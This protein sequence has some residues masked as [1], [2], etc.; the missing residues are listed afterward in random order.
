MS[1]D[2]K[3]EDGFVIIEGNW[4]RLVTLDLMLDAPS[5]RKNNQGLRRALVHDHKDGLTV[6][7]NSDY[8]GG[9]TIQGETKTDSLTTDSLKA[10]QL[11]TDS[12][13]ASQLTT[14]SLK[15]G[16]FRLAYSSVSNLVLGD[17]NAT[18]MTEL[19]GPGLRVKG[20]L[21]VYQD[22]VFNE[23]IQTP[24]IVIQ[25]KNP[26]GNEGD[27]L[28]YRKYNLTE[29]LEKLQNENERLQEQLAELAHR[30]RILEER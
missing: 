12:L 17:S 23:P 13:I 8:P 27:H 5:R 26:G 28:R 16:Q 22:A 15:V 14:G 29:R 25:P 20:S 6:N 3:L 30:V 11:T 10:S 9:V 24:D 2:I 1:S 7:Y 18:G 4:T 21:R 19:E